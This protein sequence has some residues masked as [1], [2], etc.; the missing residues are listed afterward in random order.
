M[1]RV[2]IEREFGIN[3]S[4]KYIPELMKRLGYSWQKARFEAALADAN[5]RAKWMSETWPKI[6]AHAKKLGAYLL[7]ED[8]TSFALWGSLSY[9]WSRKGQQPIVKTSG[10]RKS[11][12]MFGMIDYFTGKLFYQGVE[13]KLN[14][15]S[16]IDFLR[17]VKTKTRK[18]LMII[19]DNAKYHISAEVEEFLD[20]E[21]R[22]TAY[23]LPPYSPDFNPIEKLWKKAKQL[24]THLIYFE[25][26][27]ELFI[28]VESTMDFFSRNVDEVLKSFQSFRKLELLSAK[29]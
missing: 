16:Y 14:S 11:Y 24:A 9:T 29:A 8:E 13:G 28:R 7:F 2:L 21:P 17:S 5:Q 4:I 25:D 6:L 3:Y 10:M 12:K 15:D 22:I 19:H 1:I 27:D 23:Q 18:H 26:F 20:E